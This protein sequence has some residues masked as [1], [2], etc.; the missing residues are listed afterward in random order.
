MAVIRLNRRVAVYLAAI[1][2][3]SGGLL[4]ASC[5]GRDLR[6]T[7]TGFAAMG[8]QM[9]SPAQY[10][11]G[12]HALDVGDLPVAANAFTEA[13]ASDQKNTHLLGLAFRSQYF[14]GNIGPA[15][16]LAA[17]IE[18]GDEGLGRTSEPAAAISALEEDWPALLA[19]AEQLTADRAAAEIGAVFSAWAL[20]GSGQADAGLVRL[21]ALAYEHGAYTNGNGISPAMLS[22]QALMAEHIGKSRIAIE[23][24]SHLVS[25]QRIDPGLLLAMAGVLARHGDKEKA[26]AVI[27]R[28]DAHFHKSRLIESFGRPEFAHL[29]KPTGTQAIAQGII[30]TQLYPK[31]QAIPPATALARLH[32]AR[33]LDPDN[34][35][36]SYLIG[37]YYRNAGLIDEAAT[38]FDAIP[39]ASIWFEPA[40][41]AIISM[42]RQ[43]P[44]HY[45]DVASRLDALIAND[46]ENGFLLMEKGLAERYRGNVR[47]AV[48]AFE[49]AL[50]LG[51]ETG[52][53]HY[54]LGIA[55]AELERNDDA[56]AA[57]R[58]ALAISPFNAYNYNYFGYWMVENGRDLDE[59]KTLIL[60]AVEQ[61]PENGA[62]VDSLG[63]VYFR[64]GAFEA[65][66]VFLERAATLEPSDAVIID[67]LGDV[68]L[69]LG[70]EREAIYE[71]TKALAFDPDETLRE[72]ITAKLKKAQN[73]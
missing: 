47:S 18:R 26:I 38:F 66:L 54:R 5:Q 12:H 50:A 14:S 51:Y 59:A 22:Q 40:Q 17:R 10:L 1:C 41:L 56:E 6:P 16:Q 11:I 19:L 27:R 20:A 9:S 72:Q 13:L 62:F 15:S 46:R 30:A 65:A 67:H 31:N 53:L 2:L 28:L 35:H 69:E 37:G 49:G 24:A 36:A 7:A 43:M 58:R 57:F 8:G 29:Q 33:F 23:A 42:L 4:L 55:L 73:R 39:S 21:G 70:R 45:A 64:Q 44:E 48:T 34:H 71:W 68:Y 3:A 61:Q 60:K 63:W 32:L 25:M 52:L